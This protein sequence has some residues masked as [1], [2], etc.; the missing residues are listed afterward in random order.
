MLGKVSA[1]RNPGVTIANKRRNVPPVVSLPAGD[2]IRS[3]LSNGSS[4]A[5]FAAAPS[6]SWVRITVNEYRLITASLAGATV[7]GHNDSLITK[8]DVATG[9]D[10]PQSFAG[11]NINTPLVTL[12]SGQYVV[13]FVV[14]SWNQNGSAN[15]GYTNTFATGSPS[16]VAI[17]GSVIG[18]GPNYLVRKRPAGTPVDAFSPV[19]QSVYPT[20]MYNSP[21]YPNSIVGALSWRYDANIP[22]WVQSETNST[23]KLQVVVT[24]VNPWG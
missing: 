5:N 21:A 23:G 2:P 16:W 7:L 20:V 11:A 14:E 6:G 22:A 4:I 24:T 18:G 19:T 9:W 12:D 17:S 15:L 1:Q 13:A 3:L 8:R 10:T